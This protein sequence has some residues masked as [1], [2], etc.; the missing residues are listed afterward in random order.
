MYHPHFTSPFIPKCTG[1]VLKLESNLDIFSFHSSIWK[2]QL[3][4]GKLDCCA[5]NVLLICN[6][7]QKKLTRHTT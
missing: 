4:L 1:F 2:I 6:K 3:F 5:K 7:N